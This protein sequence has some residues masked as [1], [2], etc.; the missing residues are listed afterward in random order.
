MDGGGAD[1]DDGDGDGDDGG[2]GGDGNGDDNGDDIEH[3]DNDALPLHCAHAVHR[4]QCYFGPWDKSMAFFAEAGH[5]CPQ[6]KNPSDHFMRIVSNADWA[7]EVSAAYAKSELSASAKDLKSL[8][9]PTQ[10]SVSSERGLSVG[11][12]G[13]SSGRPPWWFQFLVLSTRFYKAML[14]H[15][16]AFVGEISQYW[17]MSVFV[18]EAPPPPCCP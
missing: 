3:D 14:R 5:A 11:C 6:F 15:P 1:D 7:D 2:G 17:F 16:M 12:C 18:G 8:A 13:D 10:A 9:S 4:K